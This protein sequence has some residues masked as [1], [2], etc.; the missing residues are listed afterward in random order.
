VTYAV[1]N[2][3][4]LKLT[5]LPTPSKQGSVLDAVQCDSTTYCIEGGNDGPFNGDSGH[6]ITGFYNGTTFTQVSLP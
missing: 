3:S 5:K 1:W 6:G 4:T 2:G